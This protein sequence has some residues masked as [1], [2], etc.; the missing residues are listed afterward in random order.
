MPNPIPMT[1]EA[2]PEELPDLVHAY[3]NLNRRGPNREPIWSVRGAKSGRVIAHSHVVAL[4][5]VSTTIRAAGVARVRR[6]QRKNVHAWLVGTPVLA[7]SLPP[8]NSFLVSYNPYTDATFIDDDGQP[9]TTL[10]F[11]ILNEQGCHGWAT[12]VLL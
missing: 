3:R 12:S 7:D 10:D 8:T 2:R 9:V 6:E 1:H 4:A 5:N 11:A